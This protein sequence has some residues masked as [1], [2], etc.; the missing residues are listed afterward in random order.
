[1]EITHAVKTSVVLSSWSSIVHKKI[2]THAAAKKKYS[3]HK[4]IHIHKANRKAFQASSCCMNV[5]LQA[6]FHTNTTQSVITVSHEKGNER[7]KERD[8]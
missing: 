4:H 3:T 2:D 7:K 5:C 1:M 6:D 8:R